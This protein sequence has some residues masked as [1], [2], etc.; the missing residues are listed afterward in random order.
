M[1]ATMTTRDLVKRGGRAFGPA[2]RFIVFGGILVLGATAPV[3]AQNG[4]T[5][6][7]LNGG[8]GYVLSGLQFPSPPSATGAG[9]V[10]AAGLIVFDGQGGLTARDTFNGGGS[11]SQRAGT[12]GYMVDSDCT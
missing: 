2:L 7:S 11:V 9:P 6:G 3:Q 1:E 8:Y 5:Q 10:A 4:C 12:G